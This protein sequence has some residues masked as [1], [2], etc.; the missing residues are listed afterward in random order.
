MVTPTELRD[1]ALDKLALAPVPTLVEVEMEGG[2]GVVGTIALELGFAGVLTVVFW[3]FPFPPAIPEV[4]L[5][6]V[7]VLWLIKGFCAASVMLFE[8]LRPSASI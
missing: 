2:G 3:F 5:V 4:V 1:I 6:L 8:N 7:A